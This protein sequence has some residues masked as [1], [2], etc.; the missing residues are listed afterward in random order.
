MLY[1]TCFSQFGKCKY[2]LPLKQTNKHLFLHSSLLIILPDGQIGISVHL[3][4]MSEIKYKFGLQTKPIYSPPPLQNIQDPV[5]G[6]HL[7]PNNTYFSDAITISLV[8][9]D[10]ASSVFSPVK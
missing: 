3:I 9:S 2:I 5:K 4:S 8:L 7:F 1:F 10:V 6:M